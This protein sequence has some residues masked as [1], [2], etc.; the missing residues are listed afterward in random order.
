MPANGRRDLI[1]HLKVNTNMS[2]RKY[3]GTAYNGRAKGPISFFFFVTCRLLLIQLDPRESIS[4]VQLE[5]SINNSFPLCPVS[6]QTGLT[7]SKPKHMRNNNIPV[8]YLFF[9]FYT[10]PA[11]YP[12]GPN[13]VAYFKRDF[14]IVI[15]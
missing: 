10:K 9:I 11:N 15:R 8:V 5:F 6:V 2:R 12:G 7:P 1:R 3:S 4:F 13:T 14:P